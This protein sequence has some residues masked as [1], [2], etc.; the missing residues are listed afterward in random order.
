MDMFKIFFFSSLAVAVAFYY[1][2]HK[3]VHVYIYIVHT[4]HLMHL[5]SYHY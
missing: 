1:I 3:I 5:F 4:F 2:V